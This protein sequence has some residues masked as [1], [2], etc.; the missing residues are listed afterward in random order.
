MRLL[1]CYGRVWFTAK[2]QAASQCQSGFFSSTLR[3]VRS[4]DP[5]SRPSGFNSQHLYSVSLR[6]ATSLGL[7]F[8]ICEM[9]R[10]IAP[11]PRVVRWIK[12][13]DALTGSGTESLPSKLLETSFLSYTVSV[14]ILAGMV[15]GGPALQV[16][17]LR[18]SSV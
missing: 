5:E 17:R 6:Q 12:W 9:R 11:A 7:S 2:G 1:K 15:V 18:A 4:I 3:C 16:C 8:L 14:V 13:G 10:I